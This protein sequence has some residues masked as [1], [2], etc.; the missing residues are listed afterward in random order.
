M[1]SGSFFEGRMA[2]LLDPGSPLWPWLNA[3]IPRSWNDQEVRLENH[4][5]FLHEL[6]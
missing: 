5:A 3:N 4:A 6:L 1:F 2:P